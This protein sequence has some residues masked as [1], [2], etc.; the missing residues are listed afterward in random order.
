LEFP[1]VEGQS[2][3]S[4]VPFFT[5]SQLLIWSKLTMATAAAE[6]E[7]KQQGAIEAARDPNSSVT[8][9]DAQ[10]KIEFETKKAGVQAFSFDPDASPEEKAA[11]AR[12][13]SCSS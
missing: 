13:V 1:S 5:T 4:S 10:A 8:A 6:A 12:S 11:Q 7:L 2:Q 3:Y 9:A